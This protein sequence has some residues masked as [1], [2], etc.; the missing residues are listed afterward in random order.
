MVRVGGDGNRVRQY[1]L[2]EIAGYVVEYVDSLLALRR[3][4]VPRPARPLGRAAGGRQAVQD[5]A[6]DRSRLAGIVQAPADLMPAR[7]WR[8]E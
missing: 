5:D 7:F 1:R 6:G 3:G 4:T 8:P 2:R